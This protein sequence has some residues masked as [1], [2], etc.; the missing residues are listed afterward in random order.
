MLREVCQYLRP[1]VLGFRRRQAQFSLNKV[2]EVQFSSETYS[3]LFEE[4]EK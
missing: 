4:S 1:K 3:I 2:F